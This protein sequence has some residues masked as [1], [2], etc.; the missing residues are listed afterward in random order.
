MSEIARSESSERILGI[1]FVSVVT[2]SL[3]SAATIDATLA[4]VALQE[5]D[6]ELEHICVDG[7]SRDETREMID[8]WGARTG[9]VV[10]IFEPDDGIFDAM[11]K[12][13]RV[14]RGEYLLFLNSDDHLLRRDVISRAM[15][16]LRPG[17]PENPGIVAGD[18]RMGSGDDRHGI[19]R[20]RRVPRML[21]RKRG[22]GCFP[23]HQGMFIRRQLLECVGGFDATTKLAGDVNLFYDIERQLNPSIRLLGFDVTFMLAGGA[24]NA[25]LRSMMIGSQEI[26]R[27]L[28][29]THGSIKA[30]MM[31]LVKTIQSA[32][33]LRFGRLQCSP[34]MYDDSRDHVFLTNRKSA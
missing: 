33:E 19:W 8:G 13:M 2:V 22:T 30:A 17:A 27:H 28:R 15:S 25:G 20:H 24:A 26:Y 5:F 23:V 14:S 3:N 16:G 10:K 12:G 21:A 7:G 32:S 6:L 9:N 11:N 1:P 34:W 29:K 31:L 4:S 18:V